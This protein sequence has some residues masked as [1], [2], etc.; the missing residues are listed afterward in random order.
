MKFAEVDG[1]RC[2]AT[3]SGQ[4]GICPAC[5]ATVVAKCGRVKVNHWAHHSRK[6]CDSWHE[7]ETEWHRMWKSKFPEDWQEKNFIDEKTGEHHRADVHTPHGLTIEFQHSTI[8]AKECKARELFYRTQGKMIWLVD[9][10]SKK[11]IWKQFNKNRNLL[12]PDKKLP[13]DALTCRAPEKL[14]PEEWIGHPV[15]IF[16]DFTGCQNEEDVPTEKQL[17]VCL[18]PKTE[19]KD[20]LVRLIT[21]ADFIDHCRSSEIDQWL[22]LRYEPYI[23][24]SITKPKPT[25]KEQIVEANKQ[26]AIIHNLHGRIYIVTPGTPRRKLRRF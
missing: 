10:T 3:I 21:R 20:L 6:D 8:D 14:F 25:P 24:P 7:S 23:F 15:P 5:G 22:S 2:E 26:R 17:L 18:F 11:S 4:R 13:P 12:F 1:V 16:F 19:I 9:G